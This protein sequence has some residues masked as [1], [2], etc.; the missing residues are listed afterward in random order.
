M[1]G[2]TVALRVRGWAATGI[3]VTWAH[4][5]PANSLRLQDGACDINAHPPLPSAATRMVSNAA[6]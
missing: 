5:E 3:K 6:P 2:M 4:H 1:R